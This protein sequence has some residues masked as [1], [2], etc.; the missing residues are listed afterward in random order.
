MYNKTFIEYFETPI[1]PNTSQSNTSKPNSLIYSMLNTVTINGISIYWICGLFCLVFI[2]YPLYKLIFVP[3]EIDE[4]GNETNSKTTSIVSIFISIFFI[5]L[6]I[7]FIP[8]I[9][10]FFIL[11][12]ILKKN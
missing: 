12:S 2:I 1:Q 9:Y 8:I 10:S 5:L 11:V 6:C 7:I 3:S 4:Y